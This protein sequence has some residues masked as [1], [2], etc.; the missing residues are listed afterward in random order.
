MRYLKLFL[1]YS[2]I[3]LEAKNLFILLDKYSPKRM[4]ELL[5]KLYRTLPDRD[6]LPEEEQFVA[7]FTSWFKAISAVVDLVWFFFPDFM[8]QLT[9][10]YLGVCRE[11]WKTFLNLLKKYADEVDAEME[12]KIQQYSKL[13]D[14]KVLMNL[15]DKDFEVQVQ[16][17]DFWFKVSVAKEIKKLQEQFEQGTGPKEEE[18]WIFVIDSDGVHEN[19]NWRIDK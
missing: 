1:V 17:F 14:T 5:R 7:T 19:P 10:K 4:E 8:H 16:Q 9:W 3:I 18:N 13:Y 15:L 2:Q 6:D 12:K 11:G